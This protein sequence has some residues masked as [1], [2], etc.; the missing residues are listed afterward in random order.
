MHACPL[1]PMEDT[2]GAVRS[3][4]TRV[5][6]SSKAPFGCWELNPGS[7]QEQQVLSAAELSLQPL[8]FY[9]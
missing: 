8:D 2:E 4:G 1:V 6:D 9:F 5:T 3:P 7:L